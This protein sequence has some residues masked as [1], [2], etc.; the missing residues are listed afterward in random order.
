MGARASARER[1]KAG[2]VYYTPT[3]IVDYIVQRTVGPLLQSRVVD[4]LASETR[5]GEM[6]SILDPACGTGAFL[7]GAYGYLL[8]WYLHQYLADNPVNHA[9]QLCKNAEGRWQLTLATRQ[10]VLLDHLYGVDIDPQA[11]ETTKLA[12]LHHMMGQGCESS[13][14]DELAVFQGEALTRLARNIKCG[15]ALVGPDYGEAEPADE[16]EGPVSSP[17]RAF[18]WSA[19]FPRVFQAGGFDAVIGNPPYLSFSGRQAASLRR[20]LRR[21]LLHQYEGRGWP[22]A[23]AFF[24]ER[25]VKTL[26]RRFTAFITPDQVGHL[27]GYQSLRQIVT[28]HSHLVEVRYWGESVFADAVTPALT[29]VA[30]KLHRGETLVF[31]RQEAGAR[32]TRL[33]DGRPWTLRGVDGLWPKL[34]EK[35]ESLGKLVADPGVHTGNCARQLVVKVGEATPG[36]TPILEGR[37][38]TR[39]GCAPPGQALRLAYQKQPGDY[40]RIR[41]EPRYSSA[42][43]LIRQTAAHPIVGPRQRALYFRNS[44]LALYAP[45]DQRDVRYLVAILNSTLMRYVYQQMVPEAHQ[46]AFPQVKVG[47]LRRL[48]IRTV[49]FGNPS[50]KALHDRLVELVEQM[51]SLHEKLNASRTGEDRRALQGQTSVVDQHIDRLV[52][53]LYEL[54]GEEIATLE[55]AAR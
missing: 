40:F 44:L 30:D 19:A 54:T 17:V 7:L 45:L 46:K 27:E 9:H 6:P 48:P 42:Q 3:F 47:S 11:V 34:W 36:C 25:S 12:L 16:I 32:L 1:R 13:P 43:F 14:A 2:G 51:L 49:D 29:F 33:E 20:R 10:R 55:A 4:Q 41:P 26:S 28:R 53:D 22:A 37:Q 15:N 38:I 5:P 18:D 23:H 21:Y 31:E 8:D 24:V 35:S 39:Y 52:Y 50:E